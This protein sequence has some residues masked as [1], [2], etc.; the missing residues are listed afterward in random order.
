M[1][2]QDFEGGIIQVGYA[3]QGFCYDNE[4]PRHKQYLAPYRLA[5]RLSPMVIFFNSLKLEAIGFREY[6]YPKDGTG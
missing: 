3:G 1:D 4:S 5:S 2:W 6:G